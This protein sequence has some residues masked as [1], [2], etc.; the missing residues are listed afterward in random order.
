V[1]REQALG[2]IGGF[3]LG[4]EAACATGC[5][6]AALNVTQGKNFDKSG[7]LGPWVVTS[8]ELDPAK[9]LRVMTRVNG[10]VRQEI[11]RTG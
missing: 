6:T 4:N 7:S 2:M 1:P 9:P 8:D 11:P 3:T 10:E 5:A